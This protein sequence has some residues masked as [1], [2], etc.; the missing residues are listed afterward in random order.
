MMIGDD[1]TIPHT[2]DHNFVRYMPIL[3]VLIE[4]DISMFSAF[5]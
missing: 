4:K 3:N 2:F 1:R 5:W